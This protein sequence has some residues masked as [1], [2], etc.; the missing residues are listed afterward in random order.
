MY[1]YIYNVYMYIYVYIYIQGIYIKYIYIYIH[2]HIYIHEITIHPYEFNDRPWISRDPHNS[3]P[4]ASC[5]LSKRTGA[6]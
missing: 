2:I 1:I 6:L 3:K 4:Y 5:K